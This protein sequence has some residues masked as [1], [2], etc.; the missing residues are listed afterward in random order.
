[1]ASLEHLWTKKLNLPLG[2]SLARE[3]MLVLAWDSERW[4][5]LLNRDGEIQGR[6]HCSHDIVSAAI[7]EDGSTLVAIDGQ[8]DVH[9][10]Y[11]DM[12]PRWRTSLKKKPKTLAVEVYGQFL[13]VSDCDGGVH[14]LN[15]QGEITQKSEH[16]RPLHF[17]RFVPTSPWLVGSADFGLVGALD[18]K[19]RWRWRDG[20]VV[21]VGAMAVSETGSHLY[22]AGFSDGIHVYGDQGKP[23]DR[24]ALN[25]PVR[26]LDCNF[27]GDRVLAV[28]L[29]L[30]LIWLDKGGK[31]LNRYHLREPV[32]DLALGPLGDVVFFAHQTG[33][34]CWRL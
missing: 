7:S 17:L 3:K 21:H 29:E 20:L 14:I 6:V 30:R 8:G 11:P 9:C 25:E 31:V 19:G 10:F 26:L 24:W 18:F 15:P 2:L 13:A 33:I 23:H 22:L 27:A 16:P 12:S 34:S 4:L 1:M 5:H 32:A 28:G